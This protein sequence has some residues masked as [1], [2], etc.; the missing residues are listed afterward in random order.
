[1]PNITF[2]ISKLANEELLFI[3]NILK[4]RK[5]IVEVPEA[6]KKLWRPKFGEKYY[7]ICPGGDVAEDSWEDKVIDYELYRIGNCFATEEAAIK[8][9][10]RLKVIAD[11]KCF[12]EENNRSGFDIY[13]DTTAKYKLVYR[14]SEGSI[15]ATFSY[16]II[17]GDP[18]Y[19]DSEKTAL[20]AAEAVGE[21]RIIRYYFGINE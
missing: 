19:F 14:I 1:M 2:D 7:G 3:S 20:A 8:A 15:G 17:C 5:A 21:E 18:V 16:D 13:D 10:N 9:S 12:A 11:L 4:M 6:V